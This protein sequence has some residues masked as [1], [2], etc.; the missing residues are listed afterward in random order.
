MTTSDPMQG[1]G[2]NR[3]ILAKDFLFIVGSPRSGTTW[4][5]L[6]IGAH[7]L[8]CATT[9]LRLYDKYTAP[10]LKAWKEETDLT[11]KG[12]HYIGLPVL[13]TEA[14]FHAFLK[15]F[16]EQV[17]AKVFAAKPQATHILDKHPRYAPFVEDIHFFIPQARFIHLIRDGR[18]VAVSLSAASREIGWFAREPL[19]DYASVWKRQVLAA[20][21]AR[22]YSSRYLELR[23]EELSASPVSVLKS[24]FEFCGLSAGD[25]LVA[26]IVE[27]HK[28][29]NL[30]RSRITP[31]ENV[32]V[33]EGH[34][35]QGKVG[36]WRQ[37][38]TP[39]Q[40]YLFDQV[41]GDLLREL[42]Y[43]RKDWW[44]EGRH[45]KVWLPFA[46]LARKGYHRGMRAGA[47]LVAPRLTG[48][49]RGGTA[50]ET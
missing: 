7:P 17:Y 38:F 33:P 20:R 3:G 16:L 2:A 5:Q 24:V 25:E 13:W 41:A 50:A 35:R 32:K 21:K 4:L 28:L 6:M 29:E 37:E 44:A 8:V 45:Q 47:V 19:Q 48:P 34:Y 30:K 39:A 46:A 11:E 23:Y 26:G 43:A 15:S 12:K 9:E 1:A 27:K 36:G 18:D 49:L 40:R 22:T 10:W 31:A 14:E 42:G